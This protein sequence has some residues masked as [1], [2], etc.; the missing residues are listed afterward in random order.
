MI[1]KI[2]FLSL[3]KRRLLEL[4]PL[5]Y[6]S[7]SDSNYEHIIECIKAKHLVKVTIEEARDEAK[8]KQ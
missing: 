6:Y 3:S 7:L 2:E 4:I 5:R 8:N 1:N